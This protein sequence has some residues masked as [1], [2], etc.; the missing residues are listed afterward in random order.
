MSGKLKIIIALSLVIVILIGGL[1]INS[2]KHKEPIKP[3]SQIEIYESLL[4]I[5]NDPEQLAKFGQNVVNETCQNPKDLFR[6]VWTDQ[7]RCV[8]EVQTVVQGCLGRLES[9][10]IEN[11]GQVIIAYESFKGCLSTDLKNRAIQKDLGRFTHCA[12]Q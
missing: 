10:Q 11:Q 5:F 9:G 3:I 8:S 4:N 7:A 2:T 6:C 1:I 12:S